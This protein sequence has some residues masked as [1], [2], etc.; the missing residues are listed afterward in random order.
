MFEVVG[1]YFGVVG[2]VLFGVWD[3]NPW[4]LGSLFGVVGV[5]GRWVWSL[6]GLGTFFRIWGHWGLGS[7]FGV[8]GLFSLG[9]GVFGFW[10]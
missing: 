2:F 4:G 8:T 7:F 9:F 10:N 5:W 3:W 6:S 1:S